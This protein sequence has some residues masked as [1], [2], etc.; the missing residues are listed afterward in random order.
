[1]GGRISAFLPIISFLFVLGCVPVTGPDSRVVD[2]QKAIESY[3]TLGM[4]YLQQ[5]NRDFARRNFEKALELDRNSAEANNG[6]GL[7]YQLNGENELA[8]ASYTKALKD[9][10][11]FTDAR[12]NYGG[13]LYQ[14]Q[15]Y[16]EAYNEF[17]RAAKDLS[18]ERRGLVL[19]YVGQTAAKLNN[20][21]R[22]KSAFEHSLNINSQLSLS[23]V[24][25][26]EL[27][28]AE[29][30]YALAKKYLDQYT[31]VAKPSPKSLWLG[32]RIERI[33]GNK[34]KEASYALALRNLH[35][36][37]KEYLEY[38]TLLEQQV[39]QNEQ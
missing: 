2:K 31:S 10:A 27:Y 1:M 24:E 4:A 12:V 28:F 6:M 5:G 16:E 35:P 18:F 9:K 13:F 38:K 3:I 29:Q 23:M 25:L 30:N 14:H 11:S 15:R 26:A 20:L 33:F 8:E 34:D 37:S 19:A 32:I 7:L 39:P 21:E 36:Y 17:E 22:A